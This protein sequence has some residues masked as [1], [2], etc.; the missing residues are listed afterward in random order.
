[1]EEIERLIYNLCH[2]IDI[3]NTNKRIEQYKREN[4][5]IIM[6]NKARMGRAEYELELV[7]ESEKSEE[8]RRVEREVL[9]KNT[10]K[11]Q[12][13]EKEAL[14]DELMHSYDNASEILKGYTE[15][16]EKLQ[17]EANA[18]P[19]PKPQTEFSTGVK[20][21]HQSMFMPIPKYEEGPLYEYE[22]PVKFM[23]GPAPPEM[24]ELEFKGEIS[25]YLLDCIYKF[26]KII[27]AI[28]FRIYSSH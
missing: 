13:K 15:N 22:E 21:G 14:I 26:S 8:D 25:L 6:K 5:E 20:F 19:V 24:N 3:I 18:L 10:K 12:I 1:M 16:V 28:F 7:L 17:E 2:N 23:D 4:R 27:S 9:E 11:K